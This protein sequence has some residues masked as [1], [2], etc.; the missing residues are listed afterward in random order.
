M[1]CYLPVPTIATTATAIANCPTVCFQSIYTAAATRS[2]Y[3]LVVGELPLA[4]PTTHTSISCIDLHFKTTHDH[5][6]GRD[7]HQKQRRTWWR[8][9]HFLAIF[10]ATSGRAPPI[11]TTTTSTLMPYWSRLA[12]SPAAPP[13]AFSNDKHCRPLSSPFNHL[14]EIMPAASVRI[15][16]ASLSLP[17]VYLLIIYLFIHIIFVPI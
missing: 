12:A 13:S 7:H 1:A 15:S 17:T 14:L 9:R 3:F 10:Q 4:Y 8:C 6:H 5:Y 2:D 16:L 11:F